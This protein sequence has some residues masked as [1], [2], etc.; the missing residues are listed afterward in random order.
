MAEHAGPEK[1]TRFQTHP[2]NYK[3]WK[4][5]T[6]GDVATL[7]MAVDADHPHKPGYELKLNSYDLS[8]DIELADAIQRL[9]F[10]HPEVKALVITAELDRVFCSGANIYMLGASTHSFKVNF[11]KFTN[12]TR[13]YLE[14]ASANSGLATLAACKGTTA[15]GGY[16]LALACDETM[17]VDDGNSAVSFPETPLLAVL[18]G[19]G[20]L[21]RLVDKRR[22][23]RDRADVFC[24]TAEGI[25]GK[26]A[27]EWGLVDHVVARSSWDKAVAE[28]AA[29]LAAKQTVARGPAFTLG[30][31][32]PSVTDAKI[33]YRHVE[34]AI[35]R[36]NRTANLLVRGPDGSED[37]EKL[38]AAGTE[39]WAL[40]AFRELDD[41]LLRLRFDLT[42]I[43]MVTVRTEGTPG[44]V[45]EADRQLHE[46]KSGFA[47]EVRLLQR[48]VLRRFDNTARSFFAVA[49]SPRSCFEGV[50]LELALGADRFYMLADGDEEVAV[51][52]SVANHGFMTTWNGL[53]RIAS[54]FYG[55]DKAPA[56]VL[57][58]DGP[59]PSEQA[60]SLG[61]ATIAADDIDFADEL[62]IAVEERASLSPDALTGMEA[63][64]RMVGPETLETKI[65]GRL[66]AWQNWIFTR[67][68]S[69]GEHGALTLY[70]QP[71]RPQ[72]QWKRT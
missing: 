64:L 2:S 57:A 58:A 24:T 42:D 72:F 23:R 11:C 35:D 56:K 46:S 55:D 48:R 5:S 66:S 20:G 50:L 47:R 8:V 53:S 27:K 4:L 49:D 40:R 25:K 33:A 51:R 3:H 37:I 38:G 43:G 62:R 16:E 44:L 36:A 67:A 71:E 65:F 12:E 54:R 14:D 45:A 52:I 10:E 17:L 31:I 9:R 18:P 61:I 63:S 34:L 28:R 69:T 1:P 70:G 30:P 19:T 21:T 68:N 15:G 59:I 13:M 22:V 60:V 6:S 32:E 7:V 29:A 26:R 41:A 39:P